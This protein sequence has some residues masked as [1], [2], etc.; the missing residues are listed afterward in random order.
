MYKA[1][2][3]MQC[4]RVELDRIH[5]Q[6]SESHQDLDAMLKTFPHLK[7]NPEE[8][9]LIEESKAKMRDA[10]IMIS[11]LKLKNKTQ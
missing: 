7:D 8:Q 3:I 11:R 6:L 2:H 5:N 1:N 4:T 10:C 9:K